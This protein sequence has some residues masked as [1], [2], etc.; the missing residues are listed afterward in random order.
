MPK[1]K[2]PL[3]PQ[4]PHARTIA[5]KGADL[6]RK[7]ARRPSLSIYFSLF[8]SIYLFVSSP[9]LPQHIYCRIH[10]IQRNNLDSDVFVC[11]SHAI[12]I[13][14]PKNSNPGNGDSKKQ[15]LR[16]D[17]E[18]STR[19]PCGPWTRSR[20]DTQ[21]YKLKHSPWN[22][23]N[24]WS[25]IYIVNQRPFLRQFWFPRGGNRTQDFQDNH[26]LKPVTR[27]RL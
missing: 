18:W 7:R 4:A 22:M 15:G 9:L 21:L 20:N 3:T 11:G 10:H 25:L 13:F 12:V 23:Q 17:P 1:S 26:R 2:N 14:R 27:T 24:N 6:G 8:L 16:H 5:I 19:L